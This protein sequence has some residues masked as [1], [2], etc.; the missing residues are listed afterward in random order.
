MKTLSF[1]SHLLI[2]ASVD[3]Q[4]GYSAERPVCGERR[5]DERSAAD[6]GQADR[7]AAQEPQA[8]AAVSGMARRCAPHA[9][10][11]ATRLQHSRLVT[12]HR[13]GELVQ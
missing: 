13:Q 12:G 5:P 11:K 7:C 1:K 3:N 6:G 9:E 4:A 10:Q 8:A 2:A